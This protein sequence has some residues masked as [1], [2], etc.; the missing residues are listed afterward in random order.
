[1]KALTLHQP[2]ASLMALGIKTIETRSWKTNYRGPIAIH[3]SRRI[4][5]YIDS[6]LKNYLE[7]K[8]GPLENLPKSG[9]LAICNLYDCIEMTYD[10]C[11]TDF[12]ECKCGLFYPG[13]FMWKTELIKTFKK[14]I[15]AR[16]KQGLWTI[17]DELLRVCRVCGCSE[18]NACVGEDGPC[19][20]V[21]KDLCSACKETA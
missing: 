11:P 16:G 6:S 7:N 10:N 17:D 18:F 5:N 21:E 3:S 20:W 8:L 13:R 2:Y 4:V 9:I 12:M 15:P 14:P 19:H 1:L